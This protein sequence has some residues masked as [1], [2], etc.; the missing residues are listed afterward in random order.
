MSSSPLRIACKNC[1]SPVSYD[2]VRQTYRCGA[3][4]EVSGIQEVRDRSVKM[5]ELNKQQLRAAAEPA[6]L[7]TAQCSGCGARVVFPQ[8]EALTTCDF[9]GSRLVRSDVV[10]AGFGADVI[11]P[12]V[13]TLD[14]AKE[15]LH[16]W[17]AENPKTPESRMVLQ[18]LDDTQG[19]Y[20]PY[21]LVRGPIEAKVNRTDAVR[22]YRCR[23]FMEGSAACCVKEIDASALD[24]AGPFDLDAAVPFE[25]G[26]VAAHRAVIANVSDNEVDRRVRKQTAAEFLPTV[27][28]A[29][30]DNDVRIK[31]ETGDLLAASALLPVYVLRQGKLTAVV[32]GQTGR[33]AVA[34][35]DSKKN[36]F[37]F[38]AVEAGIYSVV[39]ALLLWLASRDLGL[40]LMCAAAIAMV[41]FAALSDGRAPV[42]KRVVR[43]GVASQAKRDG[44]K[45]VLDGVKERP[46]CAA[47]VFY[48][49][50]DGEDVPVD[51]EFYSRKRVVSLVA[52]ALALLFSPVVVA[53]II[54]LFVAPDKPLDLLGGWMWF[55]F[56]GLYCV[57]FLTLGVHKQLF[58]HPFIYERLGN[59]ERRLVGSKAERR[60][61]LLSFVFPDAE[62]RSF[63]KT[64][65][66][67]VVVLG[68][69]LAFVISVAMMLPA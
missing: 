23:S 28:Q 5:R 34:I 3:C 22:V 20:L 12:F 52:Q 39:T 37:P 1:G 38:W 8:Q 11:V 26:Y 46:L 36:P 24:A 13:L 45:L 66:G 35:R 48:E 47:P 60:F 25:Y 67:I 16:A 33:V 6:G 14:E 40:T 55:L 27:E 9:C 61:G 44:G 41:L 31:T 54:G 32:N 2:I 59:G 62:D 10:D 50:V 58:D 51:L 42:S 21:E 18:S 57:L 29:L 43:Q 15:R 19:L 63:L 7:Q 4:G 68:I 53:F 30:C 17:A 64:P 56:A 65:A 49:A 69:V